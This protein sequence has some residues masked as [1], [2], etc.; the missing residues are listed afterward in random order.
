[1]AEKI[2]DYNKLGDQIL[3]LVG[4][5]D[6]VTGCT[7]CA[8]RLRLVLKEV[9][10][11]AKQKISALPG[12]V[13]VAENA[14][15]FQVIIGMHVKEVY[16]EVMK[17]LDL[18]DTEEKASVMTRII[19]TMSAVF[20]PFIYVL[21]AA[22]ILQG[23][24][25]IITMFAPDFVNTGTYEVLSFMSWTPFS[26]L[27][28]MIAVTASKHFKC[29]TYV[30]IACCAAL[31]NP[32]WTEIATRIA[33]G[34]TIQFLWFNLS[35]TTY[36]S[37][38]LPPLFLVLV[39]SY[40]ER[41]LN[42]HL[43]DTLRP[44]FAPFLCILI[45]V[46]L[47]LLAIGPV[48]DLI[49]VGIANGYNFLVNLSPAIAA[50]VIGGV[51]QIVVIFGVHWGIT[52]V[53]L[54]NFEMLG[55]DSFQAFQ[56][57]AVIAQVGAALG[58]MIKSRNKEFKNLTLSAVITGIFGITEPIIYG[59]TLRLKKPFICGCIAGAVGAVVT[60][61]F[62]SLQYV[63]AGLPGFLTIVNAYSADNPSSLIGEII[64]CAVAFIGAAA[65][66]Y[67]VGFKDPVADNVIDEEAIEGELI[68]SAQPSPAAFDETLG[69]AES[70]SV[71]A[72]PMKGKVLPLSAVPDE[73]FASGAMGKGAAIDPESGLVVSPVNG[74]I[75]SIFDTKHAIG[76]VADSGEEILIH[77]G[78][79]TVEM[80]GEGFTLKAHA[81]DTVKVGD[82]IV[83]VD[84]EAVKKAGHSTISP[85]LIVNSDKFM[86]ILT[87][88]NA[89][90]EREEPL[91]AVIQ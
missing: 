40:L 19:N 34:E 91:I 80:G 7:H 84:L 6:N 49:A 28:I 81:G 14:G 54:A 25:I 30:A 15:Q 73:V 41:F 57:C 18:K 85:V 31:I 87:Y 5:K 58:V 17:H 82:P 9:P 64:G 50:A 52:P 65:L 38:V 48:S 29:N 47:T 23:C 61:F 86:D 60:T 89:A 42:K 55:H 8:T 36:G 63:Y 33:G 74:V 76:I 43:N 62:G 72:S 78:I 83:E 1:M 32:S 44:L 71:L 45:M 68:E 59:V 67:F 79:D 90:V 39:L 51:W 77:I 4:G 35:Q 26:F 69:K 20:A 37:T 88:P 27:P 46:P 66:V 3:E 11:D 12:V 56:T 24:L 2:R 10:P 16:D 22:G 75:S 13:T 70:H 21:A 53:V